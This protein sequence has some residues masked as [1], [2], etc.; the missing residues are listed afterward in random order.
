MQGVREIFAHPFEQ[1][2]G[3]VWHSID[4]DLQSP[5]ALEGWSVG[6]CP[7]RV[8]VQAVVPRLRHHG[9]RIVRQRS[10]ILAVA[11]YH[12][13]YRRR[14]LVGAVVCPGVRRGFR[15]RQPW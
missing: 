11:R 7:L 12:P 1:S 10:E 13:D 6:R 4:L 9:C 3:V 15:Q 8:V 5:L 2:V 14:V